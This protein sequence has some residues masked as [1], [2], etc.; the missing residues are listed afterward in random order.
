MS[1][2]M[3]IERE[4]ERV[5]DLLKVKI[6]DRGFT[7]MEIQEALAW[8]RSYVS[9]LLKGHKG[10]RLEQILKI[11]EV[12]D[13]EPAEFFRELYNF[14]RPT[15]EQGETPL[16]AVGEIDSHEAD[17]PSP[18]AP[19]QEAWSVPIP[20][21]QSDPPADFHESYRQVQAMVQGMAVLLLDKE[22]VT[23]EEISEAVSYSENALRNPPESKAEG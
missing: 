13:I 23:I 16:A 8:G 1:S 18:P 11:L 7:Q 9:Q 3:S 15:T 21:R 20:E 10:L 17:P 12:L 2:Q 14:P 4:I 19:P 6:R 22:L 5:I